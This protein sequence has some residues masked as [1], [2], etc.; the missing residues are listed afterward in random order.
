[1]TTFL[2]FRHAAHD[3]IGRGIAGRQPDVSLNEEGRGQA[4][5]LVARLDG[6]PIDAIVC[7]PQPRTQQTARPLAAAR[8]LPISVHA[9]IDEIDMG[10]WEGMSFGQLDAIGKPWRDWC[11]HR[12][13]AHPPGGEPFADV[14]RRAMAALRELRQAHPDA[15]VLLVSHGDV[16]KCMVA[17]C[18]G[19]SLD[20]LERFD[21]APASATRLA[22][23]A[24]GV[25]L[26]LL[27]AQG[28]LR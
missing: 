22:M 9:G 28:P 2:I 10:D 12:G 19:M 17:T 21:I 6:V 23:G 15:T 20:D 4:E 16:I 25:Q 3:W 1:V 18:L 14:P 26:K 7:S 8:G 11:E 24:D 13:S 5:A 27:N